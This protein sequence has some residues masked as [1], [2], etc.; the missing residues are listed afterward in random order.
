MNLKDDLIERY[1]LKRIGTGKYNDIWDCDDFVMICNRT[2]GL[3]KLKQKNYR[4]DIDA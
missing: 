4:N 2:N 1:G 3:I